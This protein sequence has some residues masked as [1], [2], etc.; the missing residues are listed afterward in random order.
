MITISEQ[1]INAAVEQ[2]R[3]SKV[4]DAHMLSHAQVEGAFKRWLEKHI[5]DVLDDPDYFI[6]DVDMHHKYGLPYAEDGAFVD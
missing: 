3:D 2:I 6:R 1:R 4:F 5:Q